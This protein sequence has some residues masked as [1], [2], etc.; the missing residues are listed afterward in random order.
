[1]FDH[2]HC[3]N[4][5]SQSQNHYF[6]ELTNFQQNLVRLLE[7]GGLKRYMAESRLNTDLF[8]ARVFPNTLSVG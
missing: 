5:Y 8:F 4:I 6:K 7:R 2:S 1:M 3:Q